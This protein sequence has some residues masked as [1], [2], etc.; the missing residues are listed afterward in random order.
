MPDIESTDEAVINKALGRSPSATQIPTLDLGQDTNPISQVAKDLS[1]GAEE[2]KSNAHTWYDI[3]NR[4][5]PDDQRKVMIHTGVTKLQQGMTQADQE[6]QPWYQEIAHSVVQSLPSMGDMYAQGAIGG[7]AGAA[8]GAVSGSVVP[9]AGTAAGAAG[10]WGWGMTAG[11]F[12]SGFEQSAGKMYGTLRK[13]DVDHDTAKNISYGVGVVNGVLNTLGGK[14]LSAMAGK[15]LSQAEKRV[16][17][18]AATSTFVKQ[19][20]KNM[21]GRA[22]MNITWGTA[23]Q[24]FIGTGNT[25]VQEAG[26][27]AAGIIQKHNPE[28]FTDFG[29]SFEAIH[30]SFIQSLM[31][32]AV[33]S[34]GAEGAGHAAGALSGKAKLALDRPQL[35]KLKG[36]TPHEMLQK[37]TAHLDEQPNP[38]ETGKSEP[39]KV[40]HDEAGQVYIK[41]SKTK[42]GQLQ[43]PEIK[44]NPQS[45][46]DKG[47]QAGID[48]IYPQEKTLT[49]E[50]VSEGKQLRIA[51]QDW[52]HLNPTEVQGRLNQITSD[53]KTLRK[54]EKRLEEQITIKEGTGQ[55]SQ[56]LIDKWRSVTHAIDGL[57]SQR[58]IL[59]AGLGT[60]ITENNNNI[61][62]KTR[63]LTKVFDNLT[64]TAERLQKTK[65][66]L[67]QAQLKLPEVGFKKGKYATERAI[68]K[69]QTELIQAVNASTE[70]P[71]I[72]AMVKQYVNKVT[73]EKEAIIAIA[74]IKEQVLK[75]E[76]AKSNRLNE[77]DRKKT[78][79]AVVKLIE[80]KRVTLQSGHPVTQLPGALVAKLQTLKTFLKDKKSIEK[81]QEQVALEHGNKPV[82]ELPEDVAY[83]MELANMAS[84][85]HEGDALTRN[86]TAA[87]IAQWVQDGEKVI[88]DKKAILQ[89]KKDSNIKIASESLGVKKFSLKYTEGN[90]DKMRKNLNSLVANNLTWN[91]LW[92]ALS[93]KDRNHE[94]T[95]L[96]D[97]STVR[98]NYVG[99][100]RKVELDAHTGIESHMK[101]NGE[102]KGRLIQKIWNDNN[103]NV[104]ITSSDKLGKLHTIEMTRGQMLDVA[105]KHRDE[106]LHPALREGNEFTL[107]GDVAPGTSTIE[108][109]HEAM[110]KADHAQLEATAAFYKDYHGSVNEVY[111]DKYGTDLP[112]RDN[113]SP[114]SRKGYQV[115]AP[116]SKEG[117]QVYNLLPGSAKTR[118]D[119]K[120]P[121]TFHHPME[122][123]VRHVG[124]WEYFK[125]YHEFLDTTTH[126][127]T[128]SKIRAHL[129]DYGTGTVKVLN[130][131]H[132]RF[133]QNSPIPTG[134]ASGLW[135]AMHADMSN[136]LMGFRANQFFT[137]MPHG[138]N[139]I[140]DLSPTE[141]LNSTKE[142]ILHPMATNKALSESPIFAQRTREGTN[143]DLEKALHQTGVFG[144]TISHIFGVTPT[145][146]DQHMMSMLSRVMYSA[147]IGADVGIQRTFGAMVYHAELAKGSTK[148]QAII[149]AERAVEHTQPGHS[150]SQTPT[151]LTNPIARSFIAQYTQHPLQVM[152]KA[153]TA[154]RDWVHTGMTDPKEFMRLGGR[155]AALWAIPGALTAAARMAPLY[156]ANPNQDE[157]T[158]REVGY[159]ILGGAVMG[160]AESLPVIG[161]IIQ[162]LWF[163]AAKPLIGVDESHRG[164]LAHGN[165]T[166]E[167]YDNTTAAMRRWSKLAE[168]QD[169]TKLPDFTKEEDERTAAEISTMKAIAPATGI[170][171]QLGV[172]PVSA[173]H[174]AERGDIVGAGFALGAWSP[175]MLAKRIAPS[176]EDIIKQ[177]KKRIMDSVK[178][179][180]STSAYDTIQEYLQGLFE[181]EKPPVSTGET[182]PAVKAYM[183]EAS[184]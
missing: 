129:N 34:A 67:A 88:A 72:R 151:F 90:L 176:E 113:Y 18:S 71:A 85:L 25:V 157:D 169:L 143:Y 178:G 175:G 121:L 145:L 171:A 168:P 61:Q 31:T 59:E 114:V 80:G 119:S 41:T 47:F 89:A 68:K 48:A 146:E 174:Q 172:G 14:A 58:D 183:E 136:A 17:I 162:S 57:D 82:S 137:I 105:L 164:G 3:A 116:Y 55:S 24:T 38:W 56:K 52:R 53:I 29:S 165:F 109:I 144:H 124:Q 5:M 10:G 112:M 122:D 139:V 74:K 180:Q 42:P 45:V 62:L 84:N 60:T 22:A 170:P 43:W 44:N 159:G 106:S 135:S 155:L 153:N 101:N 133:I 152:G 91:S 93:H 92:D 96:L 4:D 65:E 1:I 20:S 118:V 40:E 134:A 132:E 27:V 131:F 63:A 9:G 100:V 49:P 78:Y 6:A 177:E 115:D 19:M 149:A 99:S 142:M 108:R 181:H 97:E 138:L 15:S 21:A 69:I 64:A 173:A 33:L 148:E 83:K 30:K 166:S 28:A 130:D 79:D 51:L 39:D 12:K 167:I 76:A 50:E 154:V 8:V 46:I 127:L 86:V 70:D 32:G 126:V 94:V 66:Q 23:E 182:N 120:L 147:H 123:V 35:D 156:V 104:K 13:A 140:S 184:K 26:K 158:T 95:K 150:V 36:M 110:D 98:H 11:M 77:V 2:V 73:N 103:T 179:T 7:T 141:I 75:Q 160:P 117:L 111:K 107:P 87:N 163:H 37:V 81:F 128:D 54:E 125:H 161:D 102:F 16:I